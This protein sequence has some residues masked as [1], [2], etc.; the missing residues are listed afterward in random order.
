ML[1]YRLFLWHR[2]I[3][4]VFSF[5]RNFSSPSVSLG[6]R[7]MLAYQRLSIGQVWKECTQGEQWL[8]TDVV[9]E[10]TRCN[11]RSIQHF[12]RVDSKRDASIR[13]AYACNPV[14]ANKRILGRTAI[15][16]EYIGQA[17]GN[18]FFNFH[19]RRKIKTI[20]LA[21]RISNA[22]RITIKS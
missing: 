11:A 6:S 20:T 8:A 17:R 2:E 7:Y 10:D 5:D 21:I 19:L 16:V 14:S 18:L 1:E 12:S 9:K 4:I 3:S 22:S 15:D 13:T